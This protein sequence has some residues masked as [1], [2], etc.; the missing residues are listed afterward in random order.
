MRILIIGLCLCLAVVTTAADLPFGARHL[1]QL[2]DSAKL[3]I[4]TKDAR[5]LPGGSTEATLF[6]VTAGETLRGPLPSKR[7]VVLVLY[8]EH[9]LTADRF[10]NAAV[11]LRG[12]MTL[13][14]LKEWG[15]EVSG[16]IYQLA[17][18][19]SGIVALNDIRTNSFERYIAAADGPAAVN[20][21]QK[22]AEQQL[23]TKDEFL[24]MSAVFEIRRQKNKERA[25]K[26]LSEFVRSDVAT[27]NAS[28]L[29]VQVIGDLPIPQATTALQKT[30]EN[31]KLHF[32]IRR[33][34]VAAV[35]NRP[36]G[37]ALMEKWVASRDILLAG[38]AEKLSKKK[39]EYQ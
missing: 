20:Q 36:D 16:D 29:A 28:K 27:L 21:K 23:S 6:E 19:G 22:W 13:A 18:A 2:V 14:E 11:F 12:P 31:Q 9:P 30:A 33:D 4:I 26:L 38:E 32:V 3:V 5:P 35:S 25:L 8:A 1:P 7:L 15:V 24:Q 10:K 37:A 39:D 17:A 34:A